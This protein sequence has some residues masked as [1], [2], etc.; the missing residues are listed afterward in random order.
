MLRRNFKDLRLNDPPVVVAVPRL[1]RNGRTAEA[2]GR[3]AVRGYK[4]F[5]KNL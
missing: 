3:R 1:S 4:I 5:N 2:V